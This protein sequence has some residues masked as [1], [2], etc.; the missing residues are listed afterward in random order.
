MHKTNYQI[1]FIDSEILKIL[2]QDARHPYSMIAEKLNISNSLVHQRISKMNQ[3]GIIKN[4]TLAINPGGLGYS[5]KSYTGIRLKEARY[6]ESV[7]LELKKIKEITECNYVS[8]NYAI[9]I[10]IFA[11]DNE[12]L[13]RI[14]YQNIHLI[15]GVAGTDTFISF[16]TCFERTIPI[17]DQRTNEN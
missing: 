1:D 14:L 13:R 9:F 15:D 16:E 12:H 8:G 10:L 4:S 7:M 11:R 3:A 2:Q 5:T 17:K 6:A